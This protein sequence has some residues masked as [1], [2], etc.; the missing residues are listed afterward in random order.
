MSKN[1]VDNYLQFWSKGTPSELGIHVAEM[2]DEWQG[3]HHLDQDLMR[4]INWDDTHHIEMKLR[5]VNLA[6]FD[7]NNLTTLVFLAHDYGIRVEINP[8]SNLY[9]RV[10]FHQRACREGNIVHR[11]PTIE[12]ALIEWRKTHPNNNKMPKEEGVTP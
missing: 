2:L 8:S 12:D 9:L 6:T 5:Y 3:L 4:K 10:L 11:H 1:I 7:F